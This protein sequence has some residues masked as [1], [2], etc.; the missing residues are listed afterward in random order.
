MAVAKM[1]LQFGW[2]RQEKCAIDI[3]MEME[4]TNLCV[5]ARL[6]AISIYGLKIDRLIVLLSLFFG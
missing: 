3:S 4:L 6:Q 5:R 2:Q 1:Y